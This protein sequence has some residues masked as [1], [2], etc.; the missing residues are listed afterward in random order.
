MTSNLWNYLLKNTLPE[1][2]K[3]GQSENMY[4]FGIFLIDDMVEYL[5]YNRLKEHW[6]SF[7][8]VLLR[9]AQE[10]SCVIRQAAC[11]GLGVLAVNSP[12]SCLKPQQISEWLN[13]LVSAAKIPKGSEK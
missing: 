12:T 2:F 11:Y 4:K 5:G 13:A 1:A 3:E 10:K 9:F 8:T 7:A 6:F